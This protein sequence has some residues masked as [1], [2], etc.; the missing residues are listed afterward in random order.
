MF[1][2]H[3]RFEIVLL[4]MIVTSSEGQFFLRSTGVKMTFF[5]AVILRG[6]YWNKINMA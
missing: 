6:N 3:N 4:K 5:N 2:S 1:L